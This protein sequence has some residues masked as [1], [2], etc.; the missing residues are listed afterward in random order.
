MLTLA[1]S[2]DGQHIASGNQD[3]TVHFWN[4]NT[5]EDLQM[6]GYPTKVRELSWNDSGRFLATGGGSGACVWDC[7]GEGPSGTQPIQFQ[8]TGA[9]LT[10]LGFRPGR[11]PV[12]AAGFADGSVG[13]WNLMP[14]PARLDLFQLDAG[15]AQLRWHPSGKIL[16]LATEEGGIAAFVESRGTR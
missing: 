10:D 7:S 6:W 16:A 2:P 4:V 9:L 1:R 8:L 13:L 3:A 14:A 12:L 11:A 15:I 5:G